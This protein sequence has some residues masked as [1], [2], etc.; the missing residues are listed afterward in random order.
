[1][2]IQHEAMRGQTRPIEP[3][4][5]AEGGTAAR[6]R[7]PE[8]KTFLGTSEFWMSLLGIAA[9]VVIWVAG[10]A[11]SLTVFRACLLGT[12]IV[13]AYVISRGVA[14]AGTRRDER[15][16]PE[17]DYNVDRARHSHG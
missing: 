5:Y 3:S 1:M 10:R 14:K 17:Q 4:E 11:A 7:T 13:S 15:M 12:V 2:S 16:G 6:H 9:L 8:T